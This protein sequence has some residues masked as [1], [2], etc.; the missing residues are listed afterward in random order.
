M[1][2]VDMIVPPHYSAA[3]S[4]DLCTT[5]RVSFVVRGESRGIVLTTGEK[6]LRSRS[7]RAGLFAA[8]QLYSWSQRDCQRS[9]HDRCSAIG[10]SAL[11]ISTVS[12]SVASAR[13]LRL[14]S[15]QRDSTASNSTEWRST[16]CPLTKFDSEQYSVSLQVWQAGASLSEQMK[17]DTCNARALEIQALNGRW[18]EA[19]RNRFFT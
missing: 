14:D 17:H 11:S 6:P 2:H 1:D 15:M 3:P 7:S 19:P 8:E 18:D 12:R 4:G 13:M 10:C 5:L 9:Q 16:R